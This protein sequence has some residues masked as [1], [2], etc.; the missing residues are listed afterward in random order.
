MPLPATLS[1]PSLRTTSRRRAAS[2]GLLVALLAALPAVAQPQIAVSPAAL[3]QTL[4]AG[5]TATQ[6]VTVTN[7][8]NAPL[9]F[10]ATRGPAAAPAGGPD[11]YGYT[12][13]DSDR[14]GGPVYQWTDVRAT[15]TRHPLSGSGDGWVDLPFAFP[16]YGQTYTRV[17]VYA[18]G[19][20]SFLPTYQGSTYNNRPIP[21]WDNPDLFVAGFWDDLDPSRAGGVYT[22]TDA[23]GR[24]VVQYHEVGLAGA[25]AP[26]ARYTFQI[27]LDPSGTILIQ[28]GPMAGPTASATVG[29]ENATSDHG[30]STTGL[31]VAYDEPY[32][33]DGL[34]VRIA[35]G[36]PWLSVVGGGTLAPGASAD[37]AA[38]FSS[39]DLL[40]G[41]YEGGLVL[42]GNTATPTVVPA[43]LTVA[44]TP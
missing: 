32:V 39:F 36:D 20:I 34:A 38:T 3:S 25:A 17:K 35:R 16:F 13:T 27:V 26:N 18:D 40:A 12:W 9:T 10:A 14:A 11:T 23:R 43:S 6:T 5:A 2:A 41:T 4:G 22:G 7:A 28:Y 33:R 19:L 1:R 29:I 15:G 24:F 8:G 31:E 44:S 21:Y 37:V 30:G 42:S